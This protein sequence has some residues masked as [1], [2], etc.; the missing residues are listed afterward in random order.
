MFHPLLWPVGQRLLSREDFLEGRGKVTHFCISG[1]QDS[2]E[3]EK[4]PRRYWLNESKPL[5]ASP[6]LGIKESL[7]LAALLPDQS[8]SWDTQLR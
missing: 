4:D 8:L 1:A 2:P 5:V 6:K 3:N 7:C